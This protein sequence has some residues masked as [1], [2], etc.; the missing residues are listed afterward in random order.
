MIKDRL[1]NWR[2]WARS[3]KHPPASC[4][5][6]ESRYKSPQ[7]WHPVNPTIPID[8]IDAGK[9]ED[10]IIKL[11]ELD[12]DIL[13]YA[14]ISPAYHFDAFCRTRKIVGDKHLTKMQRFD[15]IQESAEKAL[16]VLLKS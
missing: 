13:V 1:D 6:L 3:G 15:M 5:S 7:C 14:Y 12:R 11:S 2:R 16:E 10:A 4:R 8:I 9:V